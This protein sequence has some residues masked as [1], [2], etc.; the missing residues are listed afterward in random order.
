MEAKFRK[1]GN[2]VEALMPELRNESIK[3]ITDTI[4]KVSG[5]KG[6]I[7]LYDEDEN[8][9]VYVS[10]DGGRHPEYASNLWSMVYDVHIDSKGKL[11]LCIEDSDDYEITRCTTMEIYEVACMVDNVAGDDD[12]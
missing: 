8:D 9:S 1:I 7:N 2:Q 12:E 4:K 6:S 10:Y 3:F 11:A 5:D